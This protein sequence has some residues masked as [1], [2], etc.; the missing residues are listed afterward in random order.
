MPHISR[1]SS[2]HSVSLLCVFLIYLSS[3]S[4]FFFFLFLSLLLS[5]FFF[6][7]GN[8]LFLFYL[9]RSSSEDSYGYE[10]SCA[11]FVSALACNQLVDVHKLT[12]VSLLINVD[13]CVFQIIRFIKAH[14]ILSR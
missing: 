2:Y 13:A 4:Y 7:I 8:I 6:L 3:F 14:L 9:V 5:A 1:S 11:L 10:Y 12:P